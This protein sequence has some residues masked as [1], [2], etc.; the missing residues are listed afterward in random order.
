MEDLASLSLIGLRPQGPARASLV[1]QQ[2]SQ[3][4][5]PAQGWPTGSQSRL[6][7]E[8]RMA[9]AGPWG[10]GHLGSEYEQLPAWILLHMAP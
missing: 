3:A 5:L 10:W 6:W 1:P 8:A 2:Q 9:G 7:H 4:R